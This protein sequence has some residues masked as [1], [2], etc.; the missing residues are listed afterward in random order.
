MTG[1]EC[2]KCNYSENP[3]IIHALCR[4]HWDNQ[5]FST[6]FSTSS[7]YLSSYRRC[8]RDVINIYPSLSADFHGLSGDKDFE[9][10]ITWGLSAL[11]GGFLDELN[12]KLALHLDH[13]TD[14]VIRLNTRCKIYL[15]SIDFGVLPRLNCCDLNKMQSVCKS[16]PEKNLLWESGDGHIKIV[17][18]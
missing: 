12:V 4:D 17:W 8:W 1:R 13:T 9:E 11:H 6:L 7:W 3:D 10:M 18:L 2:F 16:G 5:E 14:N 15:S